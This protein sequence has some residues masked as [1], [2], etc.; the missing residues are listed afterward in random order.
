MSRTTG[1]FQF[2][3]QA[4]LKLEQQRLQLAELE[5][6]RA[7][8]NVRIAQAEMNVLRQSQQYELESTQRLDPQLQLR[9][10]HHQW[11]AQMAL[12]LDAQQTVVQQAQAELE[13]ASQ[14]RARQQQRVEG[15]L[16]IREKQHTEFRQNQL[17]SEQEELLESILRRPREQSV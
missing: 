12:Q 3:L 15:L 10:Q 7:A 1:N 17:R 8:H 2:D 9:T 14:A 4:V 16:R 13:S 5:Q 11:M 6:M